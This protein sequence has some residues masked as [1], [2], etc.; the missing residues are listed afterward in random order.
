MLVALDIG[1]SNIVVG[2]YSGA[3]LLH[4]IRLS[5]RQHAS[6]DEYGEL[7]SAVLERRGIEPLMIQSVVIAS[8]VPQLDSVFRE[9]CHLYL[10]QMPR[11]VGQ[12]L[13]VPM[14]FK[15]D[16][17]QEV[18]ADRAVNAYAA[19][20]RY[21]GASIVVD[22]GT[23]TTFD[24]VD[25]SGAFIG[26]AIAPGLAI[27]RDALFHAAAKLP[28]VELVLPQYAI[29]KN[30]K[31]NIQ[32]GLVLGYVGLIDTLV[33]RMIKELGTKVHVVAT[34]GLARLFQ[35]VC[36]SIDEV[37]PNLTLEGLRLIYEKR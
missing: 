7:F 34:G 25:S 3:T 26:G 35:G 30:T 27:S 8:V 29:G 19:W 2:V 21:R 20:C 12:D 14:V 5:T 11:F 4:H 10:R 15:V 9:V 36:E 31:D 13:R 17:P 16:H 28:N 18:G 37:D 22:L 1:N 32:S 6:V 33:S 23:A 24:V